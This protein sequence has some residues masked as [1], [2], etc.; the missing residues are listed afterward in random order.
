MDSTSFLEF[1]KFQIICMSQFCLNFYVCLS[2][3]LMDLGAPV[4]FWRPAKNV[5]CRFPLY[6]FYIFKIPTCLSSCG[7]TRIDASDFKFLS[8]V[9]KKLDQTL[10]IEAPPFNYL[11]YVGWSLSSFQDGHVIIVIY[12]ILV[13]NGGHIMFLSSSYIHLSVGWFHMNVHVVVL[14]GAVTKADL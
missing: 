2:Q 14:E 11:W 6:N 13:L 8:P 1:A 5:S 7:H 12:L 9:K 10:H 4:H 3:S